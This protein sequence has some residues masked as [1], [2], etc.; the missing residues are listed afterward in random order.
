MREAI[1]PELLTVQK[2]LPK[3]RHSPV[4]L[5]N[6]DVEGYSRRPEQWRS[7]QK[8]KLSVYKDFLLRLVHKKQLPRRLQGQTN[9]SY[10]KHGHEKAARDEKILKQ[11][12]D[13]KRLE[14]KHMKWKGDGNN[15]GDT[16]VA[17]YQKSLAVKE[18]KKHQHKD[19]A[20]KSSWKTLKT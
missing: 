13:S 10:H 5:R 2:E 6:L 18:D 9:I 14:K 19:D 20:A 15:L 17:G 11:A 1:A 7:R 3:T 16:E 8:L 12:L 4:L